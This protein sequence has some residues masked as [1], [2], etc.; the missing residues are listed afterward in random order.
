MLNFRTKSFFRCYHIGLFCSELRLLAPCFFAYLF[1]FS[2]C[3]DKNPSSA[4]TEDTAMEFRYATL[5]HAER[6][7]SFTVVDITNSW[8]SSDV[9]ARYVLVP[10]SWKL[11]KHLPEGTLVRTPL[12]RAV[13]FSAVHCALLEELGCLGSVCGICDAEYLCSESLKAALAS[14]HLENMGSAMMP[15]TEKIIA[16]RADALL[17][18]PFRDRVAGPAEQLG[19]PVIACADYMETSPLARAEWMRFYGL[20]FGCVEKADSL[21]SI[22]ESAYNQWKGKAQ[23]AQSRPTLMV[24][25][26]TGP[27]WYVAGGRSTMGTLYR[28]AGLEYLFA[29]E[30]E[31]GS[32]TLDFERVFARCHDADVWFIKYGQAEAYTYSS[33]AS[34]D[35]RYKMFLPWREKRIIGCNTL[36][37]PFYENT[38]F[39]PEVLL[40]EFVQ[41]FHPELA[42]PSFRPVYLKPLNE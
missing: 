20:L 29:D 24:D 5:I 3:A 41:T 35:A 23:K 40:S 26:K 34:D 39:H 30:N 15:T 37:T 16:A 33:L 7:D 36:V 17:I 1:L 9:S 22:V 32:V 21:F 42:S 31:R 2:S 4:R 10:A 14:G 19:I 27:V 12:K 25:L 28:D 13:A 38:P 11:P 8:D 18:S 6:Q